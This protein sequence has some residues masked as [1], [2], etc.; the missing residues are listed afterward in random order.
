VEA[1]RAEGIGVWW[2]QDIAPNA[3]WEATIEHQLSLAKVVLVPGRRRR[4]PAKTSS[5]GAPGATQG[6]LLQVFVEAA[7]RRLFFGERPGPLT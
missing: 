7:N 3:A 2:D 1:L 4:W 5:R 6:L